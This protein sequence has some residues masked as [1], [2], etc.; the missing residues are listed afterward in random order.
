MTQKPKINFR[1]R[2]IA[3]IIDLSIIYGLAFIQKVQLHPMFHFSKNRKK[4]RT[5]FL[6]YSRKM[7]L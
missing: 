1:S 6:N 7:T 5:I 3:F 4:Q 2:L